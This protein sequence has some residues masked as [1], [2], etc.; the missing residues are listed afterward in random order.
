MDLESGYREKY[1]P[2]PVLD[3]LQNDRQ[4]AMNELWENLYHQGDVGSASYASV[5]R[6]VEAGE[7]TLVAAIEVARQSGRNPPI[8]EQ[9]EPE[10]D[11]ALAQ[12]LSVIPKEQN[13]L[14][15]Y[16]IIHASVQGQQTLAKALNLLDVEEIINEYG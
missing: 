16:Y 3:K 1:N 7:L 2:W 5:P 6:L 15:A 12:A 9:L 13:Q 8:P 14:L 4:A 11:A 10:Y